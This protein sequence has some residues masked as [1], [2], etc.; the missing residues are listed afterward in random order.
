MTNHPIKRILVVGGGASG[1]L[2]ACHL[3]RAGGG[4]VSVVLIERS[5][6]V[7]RGVAYGTSLSNHL[8][9][10]RVASMSAFADEPEHFWQW[11]AADREAQDLGCNDKTGFAPRKLY[12]RYLAALAE[13]MAAE[14]RAQGIH[15][16]HGECM[17]VVE[18]PEGV[19]AV[20]QD[21]TL[22]L[23]DAAVLATGHERVAP[24]M[25][26][27]ITM[28]PFDLQNDHALS[29]DATVLLVGTGLTM[30]DCVVALLDRGHSGRIIALSRR[31]LLPHVHKP[32]APLPFDVS[33]IPLGVELS[34]L[35][36]LIRQMVDDA[37]ERGHDWR[38][39][40]D[41]LRPHMQV[42]WQSLSLPA[43]GR[44]LRHARAWW[45]V[46]RHRLAPA[47][48]Q[49]LEQARVDGQLDI[50]AARLVRVEP[51]V[52]SGAMAAVRLRGA[53]ETIDIKV[54]AVVECTGVAVETTG[55][56][57]P[58]IRDL[59]ERGAIRPDPLALGLDVSDDGALI[60]QDGRVSR[61]VFAVGP[62]TRAVFWEITAIPEIRN[63]CSRLARKLTSSGSSIPNL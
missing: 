62:M 38:S 52:T 16:I 51:C 8:L 3:V 12:G 6:E 46:H 15:R 41:G 50:K 30:I 7:G 61:K 24:T 26:G 1:T 22:H 47:I 54:D 33:D 39:V 13:D 11:L 45:D 59:S 49:R 14:G 55:S 40:V 56:S 19:A 36:R 27:K 32:V 4:Q 42:L 21:G 29:S 57:N 5:D 2:M 58:V 10:S 28:S 44:F 43:R 60:G 23:A 9:N 35:T 17:R 53:P 63:Q 18:R 37:A 25:R 48:H 31:G 20:M 34:Y